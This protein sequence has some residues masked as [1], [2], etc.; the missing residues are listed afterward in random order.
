MPLKV[1]KKKYR[2]FMPIIR[3]NLSVVNV[4][5]VKGNIVINIFTSSDGFYLCNK[6]LMLI[7]LDEITTHLMR[8]VKINRIGLVLGLSKSEGLKASSHCGCT[9][10]SQLVRTLP[11]N[12][13]IRARNAVV[14]EV[15]APHI[16]RSGLI[17]HSFESSR[18]GN[19]L[20]T[21]HLLH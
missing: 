3:G 12:D 5:S 2:D 14:V 7:W 20:G 10:V 13:P 17:I 4:I 18:S 16:D 1:C 15:S 11:M 8:L 21:I 19:L 6:F 9:R